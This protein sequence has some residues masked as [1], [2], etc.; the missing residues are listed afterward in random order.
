MFTSKAV[1]PVSCLISRCLF[2]FIEVRNSFVGWN[3]MPPVTC[4]KFPAPGSCGATH[5]DLSHRGRLVVI[6]A[7][8]SCRQ[9]SC[10]YCRRL[11]RGYLGKLQSPNQW[12]WRKVLTVE[13]NLLVVVRAKV[14][15][16]VMFHHC[17][18]SAFP[19]DGTRI[20]KQN[21]LHGCASRVRP[22]S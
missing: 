16:D 1:S 14:A 2:K 22:N 15:R 7:N 10:S 4:S 6:C 11:A 3:V 5:R 12:L 8:A 18:F 20:G 17:S 13:L 21:G 19:K 9:F